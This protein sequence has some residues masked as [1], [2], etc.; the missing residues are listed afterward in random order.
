MSFHKT[1]IIV[2]KVTWETLSF[3]TFSA[4][5]DGVDIPQAK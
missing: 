1:T 5:I 3:I 2:A 4:D